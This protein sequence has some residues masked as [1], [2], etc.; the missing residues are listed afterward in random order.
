MAE[1]V[2]MAVV[3]RPGDAVVELPAGASAAE[4]GAAGMDVVEQP[5]VGI[6]PAAVERPG[7]IV[8]D[9]PAGACA[10]ELAGADVKLLEL[11]G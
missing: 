3:H 8:V 9:L 1:R 4:L 5:D 11:P 7:D 10:A 2:A 6:E